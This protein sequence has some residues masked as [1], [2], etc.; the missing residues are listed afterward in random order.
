MSAHKKSSKSKSRKAT[1]GDEKEPLTATQ[2]FLKIQYKSSYEERHKPLNQSG[3]ADMI[4]S[5]EPKCCPFCDSKSFSRYGHNRNGINR[6]E[7]SCLSARAVNISSQPPVRSLIQE[8]SA[9]VSGQ[10]IAWILSDMS[11]WKPIRGTTEMLFPHRN[12]GWKS[13]SLPLKTDQT[14][15][16]PI[17]IRI[18]QFVFVLITNW[19]LL[20]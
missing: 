10:G 15:E 9:Y 4:N 13:C 16:R 3:E 20:L 6:F 1:P 5:Y 8:K 11:V 14:H 7:C 18:L 19:I 2:E 12:I 17:T